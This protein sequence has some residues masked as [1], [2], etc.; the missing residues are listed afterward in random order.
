[1]LKYTGRLQP[2]HAMKTT[3]A[4]P[5]P[6]PI[7]GM[8]A[9]LTRSALFQYFCLLV[10]LVAESVR[11]T[12]HQGS[13]DALSRPTSDMLGLVLANGRRRRPANSFSYAYWDPS[14]WKA[15]G[16]RR[17]V[18]GIAH[19]LAVTFGDLGLSLSIQPLLVEGALQLKHAGFFLFIHRRVNIVLGWFRLVLCAFFV[20]IGF[21][22]LALLVGPV[23]LVVFL[24]ALLSLLLLFLLLLLVFPL[25]SLDLLV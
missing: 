4:E 24:I 14:S 21:L 20:F 13:I 12:I 8:H 1:M 10:A 19:A 22:V 5:K 7:P 17:E 18:G 9:R 6:E 16:D 15:L 3:S 25:D 11:V 23:L 2:T